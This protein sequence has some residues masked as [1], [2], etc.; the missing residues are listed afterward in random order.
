MDFKRIIFAVAV[1]FVIIGAWIVIRKNVEGKKEG[2]LYTIGILQTASHPA[3]D[4]SQQGFIDEIKSQMG[5]KINFVIQ[6]GQ[7]SISTIHAMAQQFHAKADIDGVFAIAT[8]A[9][10]AMASVE[11][12]KP[13]SIAAVSVTPAAQEFL[14]KKN[15]FGMSDAIDVKAEVEA[16]KTLLPDVTTVG[17]LFCT[18]ETNSVSTVE[19]MVKE[20]EKIGLT[21]VIIGV[22]SEADIEPALLSALRKIDVLLAPTDNMVAN[23]ITL[24]AD[25]VQKAEKPSVVSDNML[26]QY[27]ALMARGVDYYESGK[28]AGAMMLEVLAHGKKPQELGIVKA[29]TKEIFVN[30]QVSELLGVIIPDSIKQDVILI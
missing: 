20:L 24:I 26:V 7:G 18:A 21:P 4:A 3:L 17:I 12:E 13:I 10:Q 2:E 28:K 14:L 11:Q 5:D 8:P 16:L 1:A 15:I 25:I 30:K 9:V 23:A 27:G 29:D 22:T 19:L 6:N